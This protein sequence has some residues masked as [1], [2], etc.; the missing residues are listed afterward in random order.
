MFF[1]LLNMA[2]RRAAPIRDNRDQ[3]MARALRYRRLR[4]WVMRPERVSAANVSLQGTDGTSPMRTCAGLIAATLAVCVPIPT[5]ARAAGPPRLNVA[6]SCRVAAAAFAS[7]S[8]RSCL[9]D[10]SAARRTLVREWNRYAPSSRALC[11]DTNRTGGPPSYVELLSC[12]DAVRAVQ[13]Q[14]RNPLGPG[15]APISPT[16]GSP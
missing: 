1:S 2:W 3:T 4:P 9:S 16:T 15:I 14:K 13:R 8:V 5:G 7:S 11:L 10:E 12:L 6:Q